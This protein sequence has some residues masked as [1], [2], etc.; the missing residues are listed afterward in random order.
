MSLWEL[1]YKV[2]LI[3][4]EIE[5]PNFK[6]SISGRQPCMVI[7]IASQKGGVGKTSTS[8][9]LSAGLA[10]EFKKKILIIDIDPQANS[11]KVLLDDYMSLDRENTVCATIIDRKPLPVFPT[12]IPNL[13]IVPSHIL[14]SETDVILATARDHK[15]ERLKV[16]LDKIK[17]QYY[18]VFLDCPPSLGWLTLNAFRASDGVMVIVSPGYFELDSINQI[19]KSLTEVQGYYNHP[20][21]LLGYLFTMKDTTINSATSLNIMREAYPSKVFDAVIPRN[22]DL[23]DAHFERIDIFSYKPTA[24]SA[25]AYRKLIKEVF[26]L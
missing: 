26:K 22:T 16:E 1:K 14:L 24:P 6:V 4:P 17:D 19:Q 5:T 23:R 10:R 2:L 13:D 9:S 18:A 20:I 25:G 15:E 12:K 11:S 3:V 7:A 21:E 8:I